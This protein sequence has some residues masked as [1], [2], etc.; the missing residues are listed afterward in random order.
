LLVRI[1]KGERI[2]WAALEKVIV[3]EGIPEESP[4]TGDEIQ[5]AA[6]RSA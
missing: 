5:R 3:S 1:S 2:S 4:G 6:R